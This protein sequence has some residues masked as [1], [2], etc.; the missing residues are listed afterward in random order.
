MQLRI[1]FHEN[2]SFKISW[3]K[4]GLSWLP[5]YTTKTSE[6]KYF[7]GKIAGGTGD[8]IDT[9][10]DQTMRRL[11]RPYCLV[12]NGMTVEKRIKNRKGDG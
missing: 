6:N 4:H 9:R 12:K 10:D 2:L 1:I 8:L 3:I 11:G 7:S 5:L